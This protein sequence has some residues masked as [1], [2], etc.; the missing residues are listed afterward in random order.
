MALPVRRRGAFQF[1]GNTNTK[2]VHD[3]HNEQTQCQIDEI[4]TAGHAVKFEPDTLGQAH[5]EAYDNGAFC[6]G[7]SKR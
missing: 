5:R 3:L 2:E 1:L 6:L 7:A 4:L